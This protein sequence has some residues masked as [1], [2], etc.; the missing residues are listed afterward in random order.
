MNM[1]VPPSHNSL[2]YFCQILLS[3]V[4]L[5]LHMLT[6]LEAY[7][8]KVEH[9][10]GFQ[11]PL[12]FELETG[13][14][15]LGEANDDMQVFYYFVKSESNP[16]KDPLMLWITGGPGCSSI[17]G[18]LYQ[19]GPVAFE[20]K[21]YDGSVPSLVSRP[22]S[23]TKLCSIIFVDLPLG[24]GF[25]YA[26]NVTA[27]RSDWK[28]VRDA[29]QFLRKWLIDHPEFLSNEFYIAADSYSG[30]PVPALVQEISN[31][32]EKGLQPLINLKGY[33]LG[34][35]LT[36]F[37][38]QN[39]QIPY[40]HGMGLIS[41]ELYASLQRNCKGEYIDVDSGNELCLRDL[42]YFHEC[43][44]GINTFNILDS[45]CED[46]PH[47]WRRS[48]IQ[49]LKSSPSSHLKVPE[50]SCQIYSFYLTTK[51]AN[52]ES[53]RKAL[54]IREGTIGK[55]E[56]C[57]M[58][59]FEY[60]IFGSVEFHANLSKKGY[61]SLIY[62]GDHDAVVPFISTQAWIR[63]L[64][65]S[66]V[67]DWRP[68][69]V[70]GQVGG[71]TRTYSNQM[72][73]VTVKGSGHTAPEYTPDQCFG[74]FTRYYLTLKLMAQRLNSFL[75]FQGPLPFELETGYVG[76]GE[77]DD[78]MQVFYYFV[79]SEN[80]PQ[81]DP[82]ILWLSGGPGCSSFSGLAHQIGPFAFEIKEYNG[83]VPSLVLRPHS[84]TK[85]SS[86]MFVDL[87]LGSGFSYA[88]NV[89]A[90][91]SDWKLVHHTHQFL[92]KWLIDHPEFLPNEFYIGA[93][94][95]S[96]IPVP[97]IL[98]EISNGNEKGLQPL[99]NLQGYL[100]GNP[101]TTH[102]EYNYRIQYAHGMGLISDELYSSLQR[103]CKGEYIHV[104]SKNELCSKDLRSFDELLSGI[105]MDNILDSLCEDDMRRRRRPLTRELIPSLSS[106]LTVPEISCYA[107][108]IR[109]G[110]VGK[111]Y[112]CYNTDF[113]KEIFSSVEFHAN[114]SK[115]GYRS[116]IYSGVL[117][118][119]VPFMSTQ[120]WIRDLNYSTVDDWRPWF[121]NGQV[122]GYTRT[123][124][125]R[126]TFATV[127]GSGH[128]APADAP[129]QCFAMFTRWISNLPL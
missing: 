63:N 118:A 20:N 93:D 110:T 124:S 8:S 45:Y 109:E 46:D 67:D 38:E 106:H 9:L 18:L 16:Q 14:V 99:I 116:L 41:D 126:M 52:E 54:H 104:D 62:S 82:L 39:Y 123:C 28:L 33:L 60:D 121:V 21:E 32:N 30:I 105:N 77:T 34:N 95:Y 23:W 57:Y 85:L 102:K 76:L 127:K 80:N 1:M 49:E 111:W 97:P 96:G 2:H 61:R 64:N 113:E 15:G 70:N 84:W 87:P 103:N 117:D 75:V 43:L 12:P 81:K 40:A 98:Q 88:K 25:S 86:I 92:R 68:W 65:Y 122:G 101:F 128:T 125:N 120:A 79:K 13:Y 94:S 53:V 112:R 78:D 4:L 90:H 35:P 42:Q 108:H 100:L 129:E 29:H 22:Q 66:I 11:G 74:M 27:H 5:S 6:P 56:R 37:K 31:G 36:T 107:L 44:S 47:L 115:K 26:K 91:R 89:T 3:L 7:G 71:Y 17:S 50:L 48:L 73:F 59:D 51:W 58:N 19:I 83:S 24:T 114:L 10:P 72:T 119:I 55:W 69:F